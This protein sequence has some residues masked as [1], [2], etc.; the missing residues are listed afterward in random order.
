MNNLKNEKGITLVALVITIVVMSIIS[1]IV[2]S[3]S[4]VGDELVEE[5]IDTTEKAQINKYIEL[6]E[7][8][9]Q[10]ALSREYILEINDKTV[11]EEMCEIMNNPYAD[12]AYKVAREEN[13]DFEITGTGENAHIV[14]ET[15]EGYVFNIYED[16]TE[17]L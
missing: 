1:T 12:K 8:T 10:E 5:T 7:I 14:F 13:G 9:R 6:I 16:R 17:D 4:M 15:V 3:T 2:I 11:L